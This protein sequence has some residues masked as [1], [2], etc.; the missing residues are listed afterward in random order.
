MFLSCSATKPCYPTAPAERKTRQ[1]QKASALCQTFEKVRDAR[2]A[3]AETT[4]A[5]QR[6]IASGARSEFGRVL[7]VRGM[8][9]VW[10]LS[11]AAESGS[12]KPEVYWRKKRS[13]RSAVGSQ[14]VG[15]RA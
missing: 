5:T 9:A 7:V 15:I 11:T 6:G 2:A 10:F 1:F 14:V 12:T 13:A 8:M 4:E 3:Q